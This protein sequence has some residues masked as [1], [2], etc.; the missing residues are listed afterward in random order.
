MR[1]FTPRVAA[2]VCLAVLLAVG[3]AVAQGM[4]FHGNA[5]SHVSHRPGCRY[6]TCKACTVPFPSRE[7]AIAAGYRPCKVCNP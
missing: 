5:K 3:M 2:A 4:V 7:A 1:N 6:Y